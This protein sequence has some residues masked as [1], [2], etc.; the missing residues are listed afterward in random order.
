ML[1]ELPGRSTWASAKVEHRMRPLGEDRIG[2]AF[3]QAAKNID[4]ATK[5]KMNVKATRFSRA[6]KKY[7]GPR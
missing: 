3:H 1:G 5:A 7:D 4:A 2:W 6:R